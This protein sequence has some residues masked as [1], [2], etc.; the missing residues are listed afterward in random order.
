MTADVEEIASARQEAVP[1]GRVRK[2]R[3]DGD[4]CCAPLDADGDGRLAGCNR[5]PRSARDAR[6]DDEDESRPEPAGSP[7]RAHRNVV[8]SSGSG[9]V[10]DGCGRPAEPR[11][12]PVRRRGRPAAGPPWTSS[13]GTARRS[14]ERP[15]SSSSSP[16]AATRRSPSPPARGSPSG[17]AGRAPARRR[18]RRSAAGR[19]RRCE[20]PARVAPAVRRLDAEEPERQPWARA[21]QAPSS[22]AAHSSRPPPKGTS[23]RPVGRERARSGSERN[24][25]RRRRAA[26][27]GHP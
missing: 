5:R 13:T 21:S 8:S 24:V 17:R 10:L 22:S 14:S 1:T 18:P 9:T 2:C 23:D 4:L 25:A 6:G 26:R 3:P 11:Q 12:R 27:A 20:H 15:A 16:A 19:A 7:A